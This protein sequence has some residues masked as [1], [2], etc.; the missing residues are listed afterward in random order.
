[1]DELEKTSVENLS[2]FRIIVLGLFPG[3]MT[4]LVAIV[5]ANP[6]LGLNLPLLLVGIIAMAGLGNV[7]TELCILK[8]IA[9]KENRKIK[10][11]ILYKNKTSMKKYILSIVITFIFAGT[12]FVLFEPYENKLWDYF[13]I[14]DFIP[15]WFRSD[16]INMQEYNNM[17]IIVVLYYFLN[18]FIAP[19]VE[20]IYFRGYLL[21]RM[22]S[23]GKFA[24]L[25]NVIIFS[26]YHLFSPWQ[27]IT[28]IIA[29]TPM[30][31]SVWMN[32]DVKIGIMAHCLLNIVGNIGMIMFLF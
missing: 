25:L 12:V 19:F 1:M 3:L 29:L 26:L 23:F 17:K 5:F 21:P 27:I 24:P 31:Y 22:G 15:D 6:F 9:C 11:I 32:K 30:A 14:F 4:I 16:K 2:L 18:G 7:P 13:K 20:E 10:D 28:R 8:I